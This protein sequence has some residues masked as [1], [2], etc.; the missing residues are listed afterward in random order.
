MI[1]NQNKSQYAVFVYS[2]LQQHTADVMQLQETKHICTNDTVLVAKKIL[3]PPQST[4]CKIH[5]KQC[6]FITIVYYPRRPTVYVICM[7]VVVP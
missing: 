4:T 7:S 3:F 1:Q 2:R 5:I 6:I